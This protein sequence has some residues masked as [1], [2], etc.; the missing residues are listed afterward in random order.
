METQFARFDLPGGRIDRLYLHWSAGP[1]DIP[2]SSY[3]FVVGYRRGELF[4]QQTHDVREN[5]RRLSEDM[6]YAAH[7]RGRNSYAIGVSALSMLEATP[8]DFGTQ[9]LTEQLTDA[10]CAMCGYLARRYDIALDAEHVMTHAE[11]AIIDG[12]FGLSPEERWDLARL[13]PAAG[14]VTP[15][16]AFV[17]GELLRERIR[18]YLA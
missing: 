5:M 15:Q 4:A 13:A 9:P 2:S 6:E 12:Y 7:T 17:T 1:Y 8:H 18:A 14:P 10:L 16:E 3:H 11:A